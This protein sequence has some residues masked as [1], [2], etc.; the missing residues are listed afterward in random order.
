[1]YDSANTFGGGG[2][3]KELTDAAYWSLEY[4]HSRNWRKNTPT[5]MALDTPSARELAPYL[6]KLLHLPARLKQFHKT[7]VNCF[8]V[9]L[10]YKLESTLL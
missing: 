10:T 6:T 1:M 5:D 9:V 8:K 2:L 4:H 7:V 3:G